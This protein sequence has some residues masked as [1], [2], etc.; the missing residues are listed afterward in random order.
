[1]PPNQLSAV[2]GDSAVRNGTEHSLML[3]N[4]WVP[5][6]NTQRLWQALHHSRSRQV[7]WE[8]V[9]SLGKSSGVALE[10]ISAIVPKSRLD[11]S[12]LFSFR[13]LNTIIFSYSMVSIGKKFL[14]MWLYVEICSIFFSEMI[15]KYIGVK[16]HDDW[17]LLKNTSGKKRK[18]KI[19]E[20]KPHTW[21][22][23]ANC[24]M[25]VMRTHRLSSVG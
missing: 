6:H 19:K 1:M 24:E 13:L 16:W 11:F 2:T 14:R 17:N 7:L 18:T 9:Q 20:E 5:E 23:Q 8:L 3:L 12:Q 10:L 22:N 4:S 21:Q 25:W 15:L